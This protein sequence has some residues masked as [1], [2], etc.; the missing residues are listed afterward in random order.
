MID[1]SHISKQYCS[2][3]ALDD[4]CLTIPENSIIGLVGPN[5]AGKSTLL[6][7]ITRIIDQDCGTITLDDC[8]TP[9]S[10]YKHIGYL[11]EQR[12]LYNDIE[13]V[14]QL[15]YFASIKEIKSKEAKKNIEYW[16]KIFGIESWR[17][18]KVSELSK[19]MQQKV[20]FIS[21]LLHNPKYVFMDEPLSGVDPVNFDIFTEQILDYHKRTGATIILSTHNMKSIEKLC[22]HVVFLVNA[23]VALYGDK[24]WVYHQFIDENLCAIE[25]NLPMADVERY[26]KLNHLDKMLTI[27]KCESISKLETR[28]IVDIGRA[29]VS[30]SEIMSNIIRKFPDI[31][32]S[33]CHIVKSSMDDIFKKIVALN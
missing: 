32:I 18:K 28:I 8:N 23:K 22:S 27:S 7:I 10:L 31:Q 2:K 25:L 19:G 33:S 12:S 26:V 15:E 13:V 3:I 20:Q 6:K 30:S 4:V 29:N 5:G 17:D 24:D 21:C 1:I 14:R 16:L 11:P 9:D